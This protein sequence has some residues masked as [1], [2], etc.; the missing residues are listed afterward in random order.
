MELKNKKALIVLTNSDTIRSKELTLVDTA[1]TEI[2]NDATTQ[3][4]GFDI[5][6]VA[7]ML[8]FLQEKN[9]IQVEFAT[10]RGGKAPVDP[11]SLKEYENDN[12]VRE[13]LKNRSVMT[14]FEHTCKIDQVDASEFKWILFP[15]CHGAMMDVGKNSSIGKIATQ[16]YEE[17]GWIGAIGHGTA[18]FLTIRKRKSG[19]GGNE[20]N[21]PEWLTTGDYLVKG[22]RI[23][24]FTNEEERLKKFER[25]LPYKLEECLHEIGA[26]VTNAEPFKSH[27]VVDERI[28]TGQNSNSIRDFMTK[29][30][31]EACRGH[32]TY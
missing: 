21:G 22:R 17:N 25:T 20:T 30:T 32:T 11:L 29:F 19:R 8:E 27:V 2:A 31:E 13:L 9:K 3:K 28:I 16:I 12:V 1:T 4:T 14:K 7:Y 26:K 18:A 6:E 5:H 15:G 23:T 24:C 10:P